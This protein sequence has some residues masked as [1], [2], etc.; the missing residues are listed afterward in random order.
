MASPTSSSAAPPAYISAVSTS[1]MPASSPWRRAASS[2][3]RRRGSSAYPHVVMPIAGMCSPGRS[4][5]VRIGDSSPRRDGRA[6]G[7]GACA[8]APLDRLLLRALRLLGL[9]G[10][11]GLHRLLG[12]RGLPRLHRLPRL[13]GLLGPVGHCRP[14][15]LTGA[16]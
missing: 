11:P 10:L 7:A 13:G 3:A 16:H 1:V 12:L 5:I 4:S 6:D 2:S 15:V 14:A 8:P 9:R